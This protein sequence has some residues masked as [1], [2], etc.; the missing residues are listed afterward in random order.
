[1]SD[2]ATGERWRRWPDEK[3]PAEGW[4]LVFNQGDGMTKEPFLYDVERYE[5]DSQEW[6]LDRRARERGLEDYQFYH[7]THWRPLPPPPE[8]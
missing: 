8:E 6:E 7:T 3:P 5:A 4:Y 2:E 1:M